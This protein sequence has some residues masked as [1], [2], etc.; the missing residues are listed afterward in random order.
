[1]YKTTRHSWSEDPQA[2][3]IDAQE[4]SRRNRL[5]WPDR[6]IA[7]AE[8]FRNAVEQAYPGCATYF[9]IRRRFLAIKVAAPSDEL[10]DSEEI[11]NFDWHAANMDIDIVK[12]GTGVIYRLRA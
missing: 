7:A 10:R 3:V 8:M 5:L 9:N 2:S 1:M 6:Y 12:T 4:R 11:R